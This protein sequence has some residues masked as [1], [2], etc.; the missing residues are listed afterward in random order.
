MPKGLWPSLVIFFCIPLPTLELGRGPPRSFSRNCQVTGQMAP[1]GSS[2]TLSGICLEL[3]EAVSQ[4]RPIMSVRTGFIAFK[5]A[6]CRTLC[7]EISGTKFLCSQKP[8]DLVKMPDLLESLF[9]AIHPDLHSQTELQF[10]THDSSVN[11][12]LIESRS[13]G[14]TYTVHLLQIWAIGEEV[15]A[16]HQ[17]EATSLVVTS[18]SATLMLPQSSFCLPS[19]PFGPQYP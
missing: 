16:R 15:G 9:W 8:L 13:I 2:C 17:M 11:R 7:L 4:K 5:G 10:E 3:A 19:S 14:S 1:R 18:T 12:D 6:F